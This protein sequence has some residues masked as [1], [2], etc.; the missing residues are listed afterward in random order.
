MCNTIH[1]RISRGAETVSTPR[2]QAEHGII[3]DMG[4]EPFGYFGWPSVAQTDDGTLV[5]GASGLRE[6]HVDPWGKTVL[7]TS[8]DTGKTWSSPRV[9]N[10][11][12]LDDRDVGLLSL[13]GKRLLVTW[14]SLDIRQLYEEN[15]GYRPWDK[16]WDPAFT[17]WTPET[18]RKWNRSWVRLSEDGESWGDF[19]CAPVNA[20][21]GPIRL[22]NGDLL[23]LGKAW[24]IPDQ[25]SG[26]IAA[27]RSTDDGRS[28]SLIGTVPC[29]PGMANVNVCEPHVAELP[30]GKLLG[31]IRSERLQEGS[32]HLLQTESVD[33]GETWTQARPLDIYGSPPHLL[34]HSNG[35]LV[36]THGFRR[37]PFGIRA[38]FSRDEGRSWEHDYVLRDDG[39]SLDLGYPCSVELPDGRIFTVYYQQTAPGN[40]CA[41][42][43]SAWHC[44]I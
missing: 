32:F 44:P 5:V 33:G 36:C 7:F 3:C 30:S 19:I 15:D 37:E 41:L 1:G 27:A 12:P 11:T 39:P 43:W 38:M 31:L 20:P 8:R 23:Y 14:F 25:R 40:N 17:H 35:T 26:A 4:T 13:G 29:A 24:T 42:L 16:G 34:Q 10:D 6:K 9:L 2:I 28:W 21:H 22:A 18:S